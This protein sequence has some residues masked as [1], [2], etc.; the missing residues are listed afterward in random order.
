MALP[1]WA[2]YMQKVYADKT[3]N[4]SKGDF[5]RPNKA[6]NIEMNCERYNRELESEMINFN[7]TTN[8]FD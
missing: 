1:I 3:L 5:E 2:K 6:I 8:Q 7:S 4:I